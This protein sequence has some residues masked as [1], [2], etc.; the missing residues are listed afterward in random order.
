VSTTDTNSS[1][2]ARPIPDA[3]DH[4]ASMTGPIHC[5]VYGIELETLAERHDETAGD[6]RRDRQHE[7]ADIMQARA[8]E[9]RRLAARAAAGR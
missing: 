1:L 4:N 5:T 7:A 8:A 2:A 9:L 6:L 3:R